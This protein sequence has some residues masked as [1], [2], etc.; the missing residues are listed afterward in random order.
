MPHFTDDELALMRRT[1]TQHLTEDEHALFV[2]ACERSGLDPFARHIYPVR[3]SAYNRESRRNE[4]SY[5]PEATIDGLRLA[6][7][8]TEKYGGQIGPDWCGP[9]G[10]WHDIWTSQQPPVGAR[11][12]IL[13]SDFQEP[14]WGKALYSEFVQLSESGEVA[15]FWDKMAANQLAKCAEALGFRKA[16]PLQFSG[17]YTQEEMQQDRLSE[18]REI[19]SI[20]IPVPLR[21]F[22]NRGTGNRQNVAAAFRFLQDQYLEAFGLPGKALFDAKQIRLPRVFKTREECASATVQ[23]WLDMW[24][25]IEQGRKGA[26]A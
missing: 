19:R 5:C 16:F 8:R 2:R 13:R 21:Q 12:G 4:S 18:P 25:E 20:S 10:T 14:V 7:E 26:A 15:P 11:V 9:D 3:R 23:C 17:I 24:Q 22:V 1:V 6:A